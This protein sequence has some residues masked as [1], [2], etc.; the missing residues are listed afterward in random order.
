M[1][2][3][4]S[5]NERGSIAPGASPEERMHPIVDFRVDHHAVRQIDV[6][7]VTTAFVGL[8][9][10]PTQVEFQARVGLNGDMDAEA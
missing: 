3:N 8:Q 10:L 7:V 9:P 1:S 4:V 6:D 2:S 5:R